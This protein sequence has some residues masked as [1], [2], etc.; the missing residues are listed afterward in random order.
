MSVKVL[1]VV[2]V[3]KNRKVSERVDDSRHPLFLLNC[4]LVVLGTYA[5]VVFDG[6]HHLRRVFRHGVRQRAHTLEYY[7]VHEGFLKVT[8]E[9]LMLV[10]DAVRSWASETI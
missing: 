2:A 4:D 6:V 9:D 5:L 8:K 1:G 3:D 7:T 10:R